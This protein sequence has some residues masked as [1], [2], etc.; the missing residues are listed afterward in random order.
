M[1]LMDKN[2]RIYFCNL[3]VEKGLL[4]NIHKVQLSTRILMNTSKL[5]VFCLE[6]MI[7]KLTN[8]EYAS[9]LIE[10]DQCSEYTVDSGT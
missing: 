10:Q 1:K 4:N 2:L 3:I 7:E 6:G 9:C 8:W 5:N